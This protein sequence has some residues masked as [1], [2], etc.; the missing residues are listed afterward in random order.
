MNVKQELLFFELLSSSFELFNI[1]TNVHNKL[2]RLVYARLIVTDT[3]L[4]TVC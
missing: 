3:Y 4:L 2:A 1:Q